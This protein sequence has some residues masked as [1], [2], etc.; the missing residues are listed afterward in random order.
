MR[1]I[2]RLTAYGISGFGGHLFLLGYQQKSFLL[3]LGGVV[4]LV[5]CLITLALLKNSKQEQEG[6]ETLRFG[7]LIKTA[8]VC[9]FSAISVMTVF[10]LWIPENIFLALAVTPCFF[11]TSMMGAVIMGHFSKQEELLESD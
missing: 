5:I 11:A 3:M 1:A 4:C 8:G 2:S 9:L 10:L 6:I 7:P